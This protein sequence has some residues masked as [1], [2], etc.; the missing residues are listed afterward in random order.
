MNTIIERINEYCLSHG[1]RCSVKR[2][3]V[4]LLLERTQQGMD[5]EQVWLQMKQEQFRMSIGAVYLSLNWLVD[6]GFIQ[7][8]MMEDRKA[9]FTIV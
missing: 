7:K 1:I 2:N 6:A 4:A 3:Q 5:A 9:V 8:T